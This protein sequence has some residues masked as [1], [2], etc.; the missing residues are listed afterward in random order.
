MYFW[1]EP[2]LP[3]NYRVLIIAMQQMSSLNL[4]FPLPEEFIAEN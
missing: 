4:G 1:G 3:A 2:F